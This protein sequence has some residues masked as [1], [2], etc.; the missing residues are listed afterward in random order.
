MKKLNEIFSISGDSDMAEI[1]GQVIDVVQNFPCDGVSFIDVSSL[2]KNT[3]VFKLTIDK[4]AEKVR[5]FDA[6]V[7]V[8]V[9][10]RGFL[11]A[12]ALAYVTGVPCILARKKGK[13]P[14]AVISATYHKEYGYDEIFMQ[15]DDIP[16]NAKVL[17]IDD[18]I[19][20]GNTITALHELLLGKLGAS[21]VKTL[22]VIELDF[23]SGD[24]KCDRFALC[25]VAEK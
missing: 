4:L 7:L 20:T 19:A 10:A 9:E 6:D 3:E 1:Y 22:G 15:I 13:L 18:V 24:C 16:A 25:N 11:L 14:K 12:P 2:V 5:E 17:V 23:L 8:A 21:A